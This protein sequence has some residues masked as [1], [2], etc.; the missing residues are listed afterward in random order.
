VRAE[1]EEHQ[2]AVGADHRCLAAERRLDLGL[3][4]AIG[5]ALPVELDAVEAAG[6]QRVDHLGHGLA[7]RVLL[8]VGGP[9]P[10]AGEAPAQRVRV[11]EAPPQVLVDDA[12]DGAPFGPGEVGQLIDRRARRQFL[13]DRREEVGVVGPGR[14][15]GARIG[16]HARADLVE[17]G[18]ADDHDGDGSEHDPRDAAP[19]SPGPYEGGVEEGRQG[20][21]PEEGDE[22]GDTVPRPDLGQ[23]ARVGHP[24]QATGHAEG[25]KHDDERT[26]AGPLPQ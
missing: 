5:V 7:G 4:T 20:H 12:G 24:R 25:G 9:P 21:E 6:R 15:V 26:G 17:E 10:H 14:L 23:A 18:Q 22:D 1:V 3:D 11:Q 2:P 19:S 13:L 8:P 16:H